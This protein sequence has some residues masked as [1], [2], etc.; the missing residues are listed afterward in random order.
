MS[1]ERDQD[2]AI[3]AQAYA[4]A[5]LHGHIDELNEQLADFQGRHDTVLH[6]AIEEQER[7]LACESKLKY[8]AKQR[9]ELAEKLACSEN[10]LALAKRSAVVAQQCAEE[11]INELTEEVSDLK[12]RLKIYADA[13]TP[14]RDMLLAKWSPEERAWLD[15]YFRKALATIVGVAP[16]AHF[17]YADSAHSDEQQSWCIQNARPFWACGISIL[18]AADAFVHDAV[19]N[20]N[21][22]HPNASYPAFWEEE[23]RKKAGK[24]KAGKKKAGKKKAGKKKA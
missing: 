5:L 20:G 2:R 15:R 1:I 24:K 3:R 16:P 4:M 13:P 23:G 18:E 19:Y 22:M 10:F 14:D 12:H 11:T 6:E 8:V 17:K 9:N 7:A 21:I